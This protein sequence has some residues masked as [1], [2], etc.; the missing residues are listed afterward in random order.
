[1]YILIQT[2]KAI[3]LVN[4][5]SAIN[6]ARGSL[7]IWGTI[8]MLF[9]IMK[10]KKQKTIEKILYSTLLLY[11]GSS[12]L[13]LILTFFGIIE[14]RSIG[15]VS[16]YLSAGESFVLSVSS[17][18][19]LNKIV[20]D[21]KN[22]GKLLFLFFTMAIGVL[23]TFH[24][25]VW[26]ATFAGYSSLLILKG[27]RGFKLIV[28]CLLLVILV[29]PFIPNEVFHDLN[30]STEDAL[31]YKDGN[32]ASWRVDGWIQLIETASRIAPITGMGFGIPMTRVLKDGDSYIEWD[33]SAHNQFV[34]TYFTV[35]LLGLL[36]YVSLYILLIIKCL[37]YN[38]NMDYSSPFALIITFFFYFI[39]YSA[40]PLF[41]IV[42]G[43]LCAYLDSNQNQQTIFI[44]S[45]RKT[46]E[47]TST[48]TR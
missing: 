47:I 7:L 16:R 39:S 11:A 32:T 18:Y 13:L 5:E 6:D 12:I 36:L 28:F 41:G 25:S 23:L 29:L 44:D 22:K 33:V 35:G 34:D 43:L 48:L 8:S 42:F 30:V 3:F 2:I 10:E 15:V 40:L 38:K 37:K 4:S 46:Y 45:K 24:R 20:V 27:K 14:I 17:V 31:N 1:M 26:I 21:N 19:I 9:F